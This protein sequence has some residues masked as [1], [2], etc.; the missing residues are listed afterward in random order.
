ML[1]KKASLRHVALAV[2]KLDECEQFYNLLGMRT[3]LKTTDYVYLA[4]YGDNISLHRVQ[5]KFGATQR[6]EHIGFALDSV[7]AVE[8]LFKDL[9]KYGLNIAHPP[10]VF[11]VGT[12]S[13]S[14]F[15][16]DGVEVEFTY[17]PPMWEHS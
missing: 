3:E 6:L 11:G 17:H 9:Q 12:C 2:N 8:Q 14:V 10:K 1:P 5:H 16:P 15:D 13:F 4:G 7:E